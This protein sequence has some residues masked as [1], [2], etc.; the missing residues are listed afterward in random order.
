MGKVGI[1]ADDDRVELIGF[2]HGI[3]HYW[4]LHLPRAALVVLR[5]PTPTGHTMVR[6]LARG[7]SL[8]PLAFSD[9]EF[10]VD[11]LLPRV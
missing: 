11:E 3:P 1:L 9:V 8:A 5:D 2:R 4:I 6:I 10:A 7:G